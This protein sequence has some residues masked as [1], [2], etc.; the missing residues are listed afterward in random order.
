M[1]APA[2]A[3]GHV[4]VKGI[5]AHLDCML[6]GIEKLKAAG[7]RDF[8]VLTPLPR[9]EIL[10][11]VYEGAP[12]PVRWWTLT[13]GVSGFTIGT[14]LTS[15][16]AIDWPMINP[17]GKPNMALPPFAVIM[18]ECTILLGALFT[19]LGLLWHC[20]LPGFGLHKALQDPRT[21]DDKFGIV[22][23]GASDD[24]VARIE[25]I[26]RASGA[27]DVTSGDATIYEV[28]NA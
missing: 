24:Q 26:L 9:H 16:T 13:G 15:F 14:L 19:G 3:I 11:A 8:E 1:S 17:G 22:F 18:F 20:G 7:L 28:P 23:T 25:A 5:Y 10:E 27:I 12:S 2:T 6:E 21:S 4:P